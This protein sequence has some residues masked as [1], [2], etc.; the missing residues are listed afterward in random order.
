MVEKLQEFSDHDP[1]LAAAAKVALGRHTWYLCEEL[2]PLSLFSLSVSD[3]LKEEIRL[4]LIRQEKIAS[5]N[6]V[7]LK[8]GRYGK[9]FLPPLPAA[10]TTLAELVGPDSFLFFKTIGLPYNFINTN[11]SEWQ[12]NGRIPEI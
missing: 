3:D 6:R 8:Y 11:V 10:G 4:N 1:V 2:V 12:Q 7:G 5:T 9:P